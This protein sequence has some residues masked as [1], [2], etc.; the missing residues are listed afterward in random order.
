MAL[1][2]IRLDGDPILR[3][4]SRE[5][6]EVTDRIK[7]LLDDMVETM[8][9]AEGVGLA[10]PQVG[11]LRRVIVI[12]IGDGPIKIIN[13]KIVEKHG[14]EVALEGCLSIP[15]ISGDV[16]RPEK[17]KVEYMDIEG[18]MQVIEAEGV[19]ARVFCHEIDHLDGI[20]YTD[21]SL[22]TYNLTEEEEEEE[23]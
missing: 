12:D 9:H 18:A 19:L 20:L 7:T 15:G 23:G 21:K 10:A 6:T 4:K 13:P 5:V 22:E 8:N 16:P 17:I 11:I 2:E 14:E 3:K 1:R